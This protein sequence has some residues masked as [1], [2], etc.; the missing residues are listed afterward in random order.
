MPDDTK[1]IADA[2]PTHHVL[3]FDDEEGAPAEVYH[4]V[5]LTDGRLHVEGPADVAPWAVG[6][7]VRVQS[8]TPEGVYRLR[9][10]VLESLAMRDGHSR[11]VL[12]T[13]GPIELLERRDGARVMTS[14][15]VLARQDEGEDEPGWSDLTSVDANSEGMRA[16]SPDHFAPGEELSLQIAVPDGGEPI[17]CDG[18]VAWGRPVSEKRHEVGLVFRN[19]SDADK[20]RLTQYLLRCMLNIA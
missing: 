16:V 2:F 4:V 10:K 15:K 20:E 3:L 8:A 7:I 14:L 12:H 9:M 19:L 11:L 1:G 18:R 6:D 17:S 5:Q 13:L